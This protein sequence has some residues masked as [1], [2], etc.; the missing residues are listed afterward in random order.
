MS[1]FNKF[2]N[3]VIKNPD[4]DIYSLY[5][6]YISKENE[7]TQKFMTANYM[8]MLKVGEAARSAAEPIQKMFK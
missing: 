3:Y 1:L 4:S 7:E 8:L 2:A 5:N 6:M